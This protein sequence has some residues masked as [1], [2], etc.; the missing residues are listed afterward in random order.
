M[1]L[2]D[3]VKEVFLLR[4]SGE[5]TFEAIAEALGIPVGTAKTRMRTAL[6][7]LR[8]HLAHLAPGAGTAISAEGEAR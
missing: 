8:S 7:R 3:D 6:R 5:L 2:E 1:E 4:V